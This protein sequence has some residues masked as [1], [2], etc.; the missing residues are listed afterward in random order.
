MIVEFPYQLEESKLFGTVLR[1]VAVIKLKLA[2][3]VVPVEMYVDSGADVTVIPRR[4][5]EF[6][7]FVIEQ[8]EICEIC[9]IGEAVVPIIVKNVRMDI[10]E[11]E[12]D[13]R[14]AWA[15]IN[16]IPP[17]LGRL[18]VFDLFDIEF[19]QNEKIVLFKWK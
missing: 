7:G 2:K 15:M 14:I 1:P 5:G 17:L 19:K 11:R 13:A 6:L 8:D 12:F 18:D 10:G 4:F 3:R 16:E 9:G